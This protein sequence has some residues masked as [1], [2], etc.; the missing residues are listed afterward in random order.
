M[1]AIVDEALSNL[2]HTLTAKG[3]W[4]NTVLV[5]SNDNGGWI[6]YGGINYPYRSHK[7]TLW[8]GGVQHSTH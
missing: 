6:G 5:V 1:V 7:T 8:E 2:T 3:M 4:S